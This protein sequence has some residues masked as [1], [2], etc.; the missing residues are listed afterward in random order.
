MSDAAAKKGYTGREIDGCRHNLRRRVPDPRYT[1]RAGRAV[2]PY[3][4]QHQQFLYESKCSQK[5]AIHKDAVTFSARLL[6]LHP[7]RR[8]RILNRNSA[9]CFQRF[10]TFLCAIPF[11]W[12]IE[13][14][15]S[16]V[17]VDRNRILLPVTRGFGLPSSG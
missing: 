3:L 8:V 17:F 12:N 7:N 14:F 1:I 6:T 2:V 13:A 10:H 9:L 5:R 11:V 16:L 4:L 15:Q